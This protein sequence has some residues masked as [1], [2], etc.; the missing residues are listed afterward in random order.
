MELKRLQRD[1]VYSGRV[2]DVIVDRVEYPSGKHS[3]REIAHH[4][5]GAVVVPVFNDGRVILVKQLRYPLGRR[6][7]ELPAGR[8]GTG[9][10]PEHAAAREMEEETGWTAGR[11]E[12]LTSIFTSPGFCDEELHIF[13]AT[14]LT[15]LPSGHSREEGEF[16]MTVHMMPLMESVRMVDTGEIQDSKTIIGLLL[17]Q[18][19]LFPE[20]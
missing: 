1:V 6:V 10:D 3:I 4:S 19:K 18:R 16:S 9:E 17:A 13:L 7:L 5:G 15:A 11:L 20:K 8:L 12:K 2:I 14:E